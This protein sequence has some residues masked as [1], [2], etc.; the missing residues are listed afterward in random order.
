METGQQPYTV[1]PSAIMA[2]APVLLRQVTLVLGG[3]AAVLG[4]VS[5]HD[6]AGLV[7]YLQSEQFV[8]IFVALSGAA[9]LAWGQVKAHRDRVRLVTIAKAAP[10]SVAVVTE[11]TPPPAVETEEMPPL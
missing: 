9:S 6:L 4:F 5:T 1:N 10:D 7:A 8:P 2:Q 11:P 3:V